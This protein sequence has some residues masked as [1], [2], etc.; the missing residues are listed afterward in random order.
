MKPRF[1]F[2]LGGTSI[3]DP[4]GW[5]E[6]V[7]NLERS[8]EFH[9]L[10]EN[11][12]TPFEFYGRTAS[13]DGGYARI[14]QARDNGPD[15]Q[16]PLM[17]QVSWNRGVSYDTFFNGLIDMTALKDVGIRGKRVF[18]APLLR[19]DLWSK[20]INRKSIP[21]DVLSPVTIDGDPISVV[22]PKTQNLP[23]QQLRQQFEGT[24]RE[25][26]SYT[27]FST[28]DYGQIDF[29]D[30]VISEINYKYDLPRIKINAVPASLFTI[31]YDGSYTIECRIHLSTGLG[32]FG[33][34]N[35]AVPAGFS[36]NI[37]INGTVSAFTETN[38]G[39]P[40]TD[41]RTQFD[42]SSTTALLKGDQIKLYI[43]NS[44]A[45]SGVIWLDFYPN[46]LN[47]TADTTTT[48]TTCEAF[49][50]HDTGLSILN[51]II[52]RE[53]C[54]YSEYFGGTA[55]TAI[56]YGADG[57]GL[58][59]TTMLGLHVRGYTLADKPY[60][61]SFDEWWSCWSPIFNLGLGYDVIGTTEVI[62]VEEKAAFYDDSSQSIILDGVQ[63][64][65][66]SYDPA[67]FYTSIKI[68]YEKW[69]VQSKSGIDDPQTVHDYATRNKTIGDVDVK[70]LQIISKAYAAS[71]GIE[72]TRRQGV[73]FSKDW[74]LDNNFLVI[75]SDLSVDPAEPILYDAGVITDL[76]NAETRYN[77]RLTP[78]S[79]M[80]R[81]K[82]FLANGFSNYPSDFFKFV[83]GEGNT[84]MVYNDPTATGCDAEAGTFADEGGDILIGPDFLFQAVLYTFTHP[85]TWNQYKGVRDN[86]K[87]SFAVRYY[88]N[89]G[90]HQ[91]AIA[92]VKKLAYKPN[93][94]KADFQVWI[95]SVST[96]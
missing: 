69:S 74:E 82:T 68:G 76:E 91:Q 79:N 88:D 23:S 87:K 54:F 80:N 55:A 81:W 20:F 43:L 46:Y 2:T 12:D 28:T 44:G 25:D 61:Q 47:I 67:Y 27:S 72:Q 52:G 30:T 18:Q 95:K 93:E 32:P 34:G 86:P 13:K 58:N 70:D 4:V 10:I 9:S 42:Y 38:Q 35:A 8:S 62:R 77:V 71:L 24:H 90:V 96:V 92:F 31:E 59:Y 14:K 21:V 50:I 64:I 84:D 17:A 78:A 3:S 73:D 45:T 1:R 16:V 49:P 22:T 6:V 83:R 39:T 94:S 63:G 48:D 60:S 19:N 85:F 11:I 15:S 41:G 75:Q 5:D 66:I 33:G 7:L 65:E 53:D 51:R 89:D 57:C 26:V 56:A 36:V 37:D 29:I 40:G